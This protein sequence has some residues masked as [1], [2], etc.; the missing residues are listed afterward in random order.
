[1]LVAARLYIKVSIYLKVSI[2]LSTGCRQTR[3]WVR[4]TN[5]VSNSDR[6]NGESRGFPPIYRFCL[7]LR[8]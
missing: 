6:V 8:F 3:S 2:S 4:L 7:Q 1:M 5:S